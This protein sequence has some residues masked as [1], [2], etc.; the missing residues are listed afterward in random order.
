MLSTPSCKGQ[1]RWSDA[2]RRGFQSAWIAIRRSRSRSQRSPAKSCRGALQCTTDAAVEPAALTLGRIARLSR[3][4]SR[5]T[6]GCPEFEA[7]DFYHDENWQSRHRY[8]PAASSQGI[9]WRFAPT[10]LPVRALLRRSCRERRFVRFSLQMAATAPL[11][12]RPRS[13]HSPM[14]IRSATIP[15]FRELTLRSPWRSQSR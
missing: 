13:L 14:P 4:P 11:R 7:V 12:R 2:D 10:E 6:P 5:T 9:T 15:A 3:R 8:Q 1:R